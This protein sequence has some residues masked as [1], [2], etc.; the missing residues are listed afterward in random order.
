MI[1]RVIKFIIAFYAI[2]ILTYLVTKFNFLT[3]RFQ[4][5]ST[6]I[7]AFE[8]LTIVSLGLVFYKGLLQNNSKIKL[9]ERPSFWIVTGIFFFSFL[10]MPYHLLFS[11]LVESKHEWRYILAAALFYLPYIMNFVLLIK[12]FSCKKPLTI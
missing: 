12:A 2:L 11:L 4:Y 1:K 8:F 5:I 9:F 10:S 6:I 7:S 3:E